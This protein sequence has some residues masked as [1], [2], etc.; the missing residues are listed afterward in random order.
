MPLQL[1]LDG[2]WWDVL[3]VRVEVDVL[4]RRSEAAATEEAAMAAETAADAFA[5][6]NDSSEGG[7]SAEE[8]TQQGGGG[9][10]EGAE[11]T[12]GNTKTF[13]VLRFVV[14]SPRHPDVSGRVGAYV[15]RP[16][17]RWE[18]GKWFCDSTL[19]PLPPACIESAAATATAAPGSAQP[20]LAVAVRKPGEEEVDATPPSA[21]PSAAGVYPIGPHV[22][23][24][25][26]TT[27]DTSTDPSSLALYGLKGVS[28]DE[29]GGLRVRV[30]SRDEGS[31]LAVEV[32]VALGY[33][34][35]RGISVA[36]DDKEGN[37]WV[38][39]LGHSWEWRP[40]HEDDRAR[41]H[42]EHG[43]YR[44]AAPRMDG[45]AACPHLAD[46]SRLYQR[47]ADDTRR[48]ARRLPPEAWPEGEARRML[49]VGWEC[50]HVGI[51]A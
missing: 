47:R 20:V 5:E 10:G 48:Q 32:G 29:V 17:W 1:W 31:R 15:L 40:P 25:L 39:P 27:R 9:G 50:G 38:N 22:A 37:V 23:P 42:P 51:C 41:R 26:P 44:Y 36:L 12:G 28:V 14:A 16:N 24:T 43:G 11:K 34:H 7:G 6:L 13:R 3:L 8:G 4:T 35:G 49:Y 45:G 30:W 46:R 19:Q 33:V 2:L 21:A 18:G